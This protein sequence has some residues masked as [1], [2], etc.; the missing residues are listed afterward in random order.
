MGN[1]RKDRLGE[2]IKKIIG[3][4]LIREIKD[5]RLSTSLISISEV[6]VTRDGSYATVYIS[7]FG[8]NS[9]EKTEEELAA[10]RKDILDAFTSAK[11]LIKKRIGQQVKLRHIPE[12]VFKMDGSIEYGRHMEEL[13]KNL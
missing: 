2:E 7:D 10:H 4:M 9:N 11:G 6:D 12:L 8:L 1:Y 13:F 5:P 3:E